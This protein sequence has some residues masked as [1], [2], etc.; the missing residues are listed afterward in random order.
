MTLLLP[1]ISAAA[2]VPVPAGTGTQIGACPLPDAGTGTRMMLQLF[3]DRQVLMGLAF[4][5]GQGLFRS[6][7]CSLSCAAAEGVSLL[8]DSSPLRATA[9]VGLALVAGLAGCRLVAFGHAFLL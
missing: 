9:H 8:A 2:A 1:V 6:G 5:A 4:L 3:P 7:D